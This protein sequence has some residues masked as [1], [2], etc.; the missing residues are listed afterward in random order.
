MSCAVVLCC[1]FLK[2]MFVNELNVVIIYY[3]QFLLLLRCGIILSHMLSV[4]YNSC[5]LYVAINV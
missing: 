2:T 3:Y 1:E 4:H 5:T